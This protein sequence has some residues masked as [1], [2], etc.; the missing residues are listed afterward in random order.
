MVTLER[1]PLRGQSAY[2]EGQTIGQTHG[3]TVG[4]NTIATVAHTALTSLS[5]SLCYT[6]THTSPAVASR[7]AGTG[8]IFL[9]FFLSAGVGSGVEEAKTK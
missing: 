5:L 2:T 8:I 1:A 9:L 3:Q 4:P 6:H 7:H